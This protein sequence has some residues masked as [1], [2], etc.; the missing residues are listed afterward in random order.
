M[1][2]SECNIRTNFC[3]LRKL[4]G[5]SPLFDHS[6]LIHE[7]LD[8]DFRLARLKERFQQHQRLMEETQA[9]IK[10]LRQWIA[11]IPSGVVSPKSEG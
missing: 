11:N 10:E 9:E 1:L 5:E 2:L 6:T 7:E 8:V 3:R 4:R